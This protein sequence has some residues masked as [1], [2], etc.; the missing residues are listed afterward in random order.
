[1]CIRVSVYVCPGHTW[2]KNSV[3]RLPPL[4]SKGVKVNRSHR[5]IEQLNFLRN[6]PMR[7]V[8]PLR[9]LLGHQATAFFP[10]MHGPG[11]IVCVSMYHCLLCTG[12]SLSVSG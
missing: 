1:M 7:P 12:I 5:T 8:D 10:C 3:A 9:D 11:I 6:C 4:V 2:K